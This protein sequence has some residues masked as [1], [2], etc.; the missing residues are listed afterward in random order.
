MNA[1]RFLTL[2][3]T[4]VVAA[5]T[6]AGVALAAAPSPVAAHASIAAA[7][8]GELRG[9]LPPAATTVILQPINAKANRDG[10]GEALDR[11]VRSAGFAVAADQSAAPAAHVIRFA[12]T[13][14]FEGFVLSLE[15][16]GQATTRL[17]RP[18]NTGAF[19]ASG[20]MTVRDTQ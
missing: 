12:V 3:A 15:F 9:V 16:G 11:A 13:P 6:G 14:A 18:D 2:A 5:S 10:F 20:P 8:V 17:F 19:V 1:H 7:T 4:A